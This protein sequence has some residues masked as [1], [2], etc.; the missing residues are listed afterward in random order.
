[1]SAPVD[2]YAIG[3]SLAA[4]CAPGLPSY[5]L[6]DST[7]ALALYARTGATMNQ[8]MVC[9][10]P[11]SAADQADEG[12]G[13]AHA[14]MHEYPKAFLVQYPF[15][16]QFHFAIPKLSASVIAEISEKSGIA[17]A[18]VP[19]AMFAG[20]IHEQ[21]TVE[22][23]TTSGAMQQAW[24]DFSTMWSD[25]VSQNYSK[26]YGDT[27]AIINTAA[28]Q[29]FS[30]AEQNYYQVSVDTHDFVLPFGSASTD[31][32][33]AA[34]KASQAAGTALSGAL[35]TVVNGGTLDAYASNFLTQKLIPLHQENENRVHAAVSDPAFPAYAAHLGTDA[36]VWLSDAGA[37]PL[38]GLPSNFSLL[39]KMTGLLA[40]PKIAP[41][42]FFGSPATRAILSAAISGP[43][44]S[45]SSL[46]PAAKA[47]GV[48]TV[49]GS[50]LGA[51]LG[52]AIGQPVLGALAGA[53]LGALGGY[54]YQA[55]ASPAGGMGAL[56]AL[57]T[58]APAPPSVG[59]PIGTNDVINYAVYVNARM[60][61]F[62]N[63][64]ASWH[65]AGNWDVGGVPNCNTAETCHPQYYQVLTLANALDSANLVPQEI[66]VWLQNWRTFFP[67][68]STDTVTLEAKVQL[69]GGFGGPFQD[70]KGWHQQLQSLATTA[71]AFGLP[72][73][74]DPGGL[75]AP[76]TLAQ[77][78][79]SSGVPALAENAVSSALPTVGAIV[80]AGLAGLG[81][82][83]YYEHRKKTRDVRALRAFRR[84]RR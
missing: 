23:D 24:N 61:E 73:V 77:E 14:I 65:T 67:T 60:T 20:L 29:P 8:W 80:L 43:S 82:Y 79:Q 30:Q 81:G 47:I 44:P 15:G 83:A 32:L 9:D 71:N 62:S 13:T 56:G 38:L 70:V 4:G 6:W 41:S 55:K 53:A 18:D 66:Y 35:S 36:N 54:A 49:G 10:E 50:G 25:V 33:L 72:N 31:T 46:S 51:A 74:P 39:A 2:T 5:W 84:S 76:A 78:I 75:A 52:I 45:S 28:N 21:I 42:R 1:V 27:Q 3:G 59:W 19:L 34:V 26:A 17:A 11:I 16:P 37:A 22:I 7:A 12:E 57:A 64:W 48:G 69:L 63:A 68:V 58:T 40:S